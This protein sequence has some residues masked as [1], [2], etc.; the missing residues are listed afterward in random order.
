[1]K[2][3]AIYIALFVVQSAMMYRNYCN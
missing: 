1:V 3:F 2:W